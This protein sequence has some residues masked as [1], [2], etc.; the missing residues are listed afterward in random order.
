MLQAKF[1]PLLPSVIG[2]YFSCKGFPAIN[3]IVILPTEAVALI[4]LLLKYCLCKPLLY[5]YY[6]FFDPVKQNRGD[7]SLVPFSVSK[8]KAKKK[9]C[10]R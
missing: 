10:F 1:F 4:H 2:R 3:T 7:A 5:N 6:S 9:M 8:E